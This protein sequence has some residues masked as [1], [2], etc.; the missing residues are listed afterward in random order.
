M[1]YTSGVHKNPRSHIEILGD[2]MVK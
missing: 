2:R 1:T